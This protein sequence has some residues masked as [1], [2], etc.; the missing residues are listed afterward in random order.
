LH[1]IEPYYNWRGL[2]TAEE[3]DRS[4]FFEREYSEFEF[5]HSI[6]NYCIHPQWDHIGSPTLFIKILYVDYDEGFAVLE[7]FGEWND[8]VNNDIMYL[9]REV[10]DSLIGCGISK[11]I[12]VGENVLNFHSDDDSYYDEWFNEVEDEGGWMAMLNLRHHVLDEFQGSG[13]DQYFVMGG[14][15]ADF[16]WRTLT[17]GQFLE[18]VSAYV[19]KRLG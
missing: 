18:T 9:K 6:Y 4:P 17:P 7:M 8:A 2:Y 5:T 15:L 16:S 12:L 1:T 19:K 11:F 3:D 14:K 10:L 13:L